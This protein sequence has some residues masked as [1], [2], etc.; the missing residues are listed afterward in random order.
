[1]GVMLIYSLLLSDVEDKTYEYGMLRALG[2]PH[3]SLIELLVIQAIF[4]S[5]PGILCGLVFALILSIPITYLMASYASY[6]ANYFLEPSAIYF[7][8]I[9]GILMPLISNIIPIQR[10]LSRTLRDSLDIYH[11]TSQ[12]ITVQMI[13]LESLGLNPWQIISAIMMISIGFLIYYVVPLSFI[14]L[15]ISVFLTILN[16]ILLGMLIGATIIATLFQPI[17]ERQVLKLLLWG[18]DCN[19]EVLIKKSLSGHRSRNRKTGLM[20]SICLSFIIFSGAM[21]TLQTNAIIDNVKAGIGSDIVIIAATT[22]TPLQEDQMRNFLELELKKSPENQIVLSYSFLTYPMWSMHD[23]RG[24]YVSNLAGFPWHQLN[25]YGVDKD[26]LNSVYGEYVILSEVNSQFSYHGIYDDKSKPDIIRSLYDDAGQ[27]ILPIESQLQQEQGLDEFF[28]PDIIVSSPSK[29][30][31]ENDIHKS[32]QDDIYEL[33]TDYLD[34]ICSE[35]LRYGSYIDTSSPIKMEISAHYTKHK[36]MTIKILMKIRSMVTKMSGFF[37]SSY[38]E[39]AIS[40]PLLLSMDQYQGILDDIY[41]IQRQGY[42]SEGYTEEET[43][44]EIG[45]NNFS[46]PPKQRVFIKIKPN[47]PLRDREIV[48]NGLRNFIEDSTTVVL[49]TTDLLETTDVATFVLLLFFDLIAVI[50]CAM[51]F[52]VLWISFTSN[53]KENSWE[54]GVLRAIGLSAAQVTRVYIYEALCIIISALILG[55]A[56]GLGIALTLTLQFNLFTEMPFQ[57]DFPYFLFASVTIMSIFIAIGGSYLASR[58]IK[59]IQIAQ[60]LKGSL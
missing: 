31:D 52:F 42:L 33:Y 39:L 48:M 50:S 53:I 34:I 44:E 43:E 11:Q 36:T 2:L 3:N 35:A 14:F 47:S 26:F 25:V 21:F 40:S 54:F 27:E 60:V 16:G 9:L 12:Q 58:D 23:V 4:Y 56:T 29:G 7:A 46:T 59:K 51:S 13:K 17:L 55:S 5:I 20:Y 38:R 8:L 45:K 24:N 19:L 37:F 32:L 30:E 15:N 57:F 6:E 18:K 41:S 22:I 28:I 1:M 10:A 49:D